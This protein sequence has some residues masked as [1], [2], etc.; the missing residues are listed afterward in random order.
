M[1]YGSVGA[2]LQQAT[3]TA[4][5]VDARQMPVAGALVVLSD[6]LGAE[7]HRV[8][9][10]AAGRAV[11]SAIAPGR[12]QLTTETVTPPLIE[13]P[14]SV[15]G[16]LPLE[17]TVQV[18]AAVTDRVVV[19]G[20]ADETTARGS[21]AAGSI[22]RVPARVRSRAIQD[23][24]ATLPGWS[25]E[26]NGLLHTRGVDD[27]FLYVVDGV[28]VYERLD[29]VSGIAPEVSAIGSIN[30]I[31]G[32]VPPEFGYK[33][34][35]V[36]DVRS[37]MAREW[38]GRVEGLA[39]SD[40]SGDG[41]AAIGGT[42]G[43]R[44]GF[45]VGGAATTSDRYLDPVHPDNL[46][47]HGGQANTFGQIEWAA[48]SV[49]RLS[50]GWGAGRAT[51]DV[52]NNEDQE[53]AGQDQRQRIGQAFVNATW[54]RT[55]LTSVA[56]QAA[57]YYR[58][59]DASLDGSPL[60]T[61]LEAHADRTLRRTGLLFAA[62]KQ[63]Q[64]H[65][66]K[67]GLEWQRLSIDE[68][69]G[70]AI[71]DEDEAREAGFREEALVFDRDNPFHFAG[72]ETPTLFAVYVQDT[73]RPSA[74][75]TVSGGVRFDRSRL[76]LPRTQWSPRAG[77][78]LR[79]NDRTL[80]RGSASRYFQPP[81]PENLLLSSSEEARALSSIVVE[82][83][84]GGADIEPERQWGMELGLERRVGHARVDVAYWRRWM[85][86]VADP[87]VFAGTTIIF[88][89]AV[90][91]GRAQ[92]FEA[93]VEVPRVRGWSGYANLAVSKVVQTGPINGGLFLEDE[94]EEIGPGVEFIPD[95]DQRV[96][97]GGGVSWE[98]SAS[99]VMVSLT[100]RYETGTPVP[101]EEDELDELLEQPGAEMVDFEDGRV[102][103][104]TVVSVLARVPLFRTALAA[105]SL[106]VQV[107]NIFDARYAYNF[108]NPF[109]GTHF[110]APRTGAVSLRVEF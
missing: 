102:K 101:V 81:Q 2:Q 7:L 61:P 70:F 9:T 29:A 60:D 20:F 12:Y 98:H 79:F 13:L 63:H 37:A 83:Q 107:L 56:A 21:M 85:H 54:Q 72:A 76:L 43:E 99:G 16:A 48:S 30:V 46:H 94:V 3:V 110:G 40:R 44:V 38:S 87:N 8:T 77:F 4:I 39:G 106:G 51:F 90:D 71:T 67:A 24:V 62:A 93:R 64:A 88:P 65:L 18:P 15:T 69:F 5:V 100:T 97:A 50:T 96:T 14:V 35:G 57:L 10:D 45:R 27:G 49:D 109:S 42:I 92:G 86:D 11:F 75:L 26:D 34:G 59:A 103:P 58:H 73:W 74:R 25:T 28:P 22:A 55:L 36:I 47:N 19:E 23:V 84:E 108:G 104:R 41:T 105:G 80:L 66:I 68:T 31:T 6:E 32:Y 1:V 52:P 53:E 33:A 89:N 78:A 82:G 95:H 17:I 91:M